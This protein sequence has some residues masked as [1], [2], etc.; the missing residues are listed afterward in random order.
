LI[1]SRIPS[2]GATLEYRLGLEV[3]V[4]LVHSARE[5]VPRI[6]LKQEEVPTF[7]LI[8]NILFLLFS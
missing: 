7:W 4:Y 5:K 1:I 3:T 8:S 2:E 6:G